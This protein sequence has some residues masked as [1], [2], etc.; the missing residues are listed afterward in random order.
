VDAA[1][2]V[3]WSPDG[4]EVAA[5]HGNLVLA[6]DPATAAERLVISTGLL[7]RGERF[8][9]DGQWIYFAGGA[10]GQGASLY[11]VR[12]DGTGMERIGVPAYFGA[13]DFAPSP[14]PDGR[15][16]A[17]VTQRPPGLNQGETR[18]EIFDLQ[19]GTA[20]DPKLKGTY[21]AWSPT[22]DRLA[23]ADLANRLHVVVPDGTE[24]RLLGDMG[25]K[26]NWIDWSPDGQWLLVSTLWG[27]PPTLVNT[28]SGMMLPL[29]WAATD[30]EAAWRP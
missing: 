10:L 11:R 26:V 22:G 9:R 6:L 20:A 15:Y 30:G 4:N 5:A 12:R 27:R 2:G 14:S 21:V 7:V 17:Y 23:Y 13:A 3:A 28:T 1:Q 29:G 16:V 25:A 24:I 18:V 8:S 19:T